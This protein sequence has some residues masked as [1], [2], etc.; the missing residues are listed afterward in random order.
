MREAY[1]TTALSTTE[2]EK[3]RPA[4]RDLLMSNKF[5]LS[6]I[7]DYAGK[8][9]NC[10]FSFMAGLAQNQPSRPRSFHSIGGLGSCSIAGLVL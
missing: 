10:R 6:D 9:F 4:L 3:N 1:I 5:A 8:Q 2:L 7:K